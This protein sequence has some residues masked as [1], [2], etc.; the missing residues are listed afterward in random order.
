MVNPT[1]QYNPSVEYIGDR[2]PEYMRNEKSGQDSAVYS[3]YLS[4]I[5][6][7]KDTSLGEAKMEPLVR[8]FLGL[9]LEEDPEDYVRRRI[10]PYYREAQE[11]L[12]KNNVA[13]IDS[14]KA[15]DHLKAVTMVWT[16]LANE[17][18][19][20]HIKKT[21]GKFKAKIA[22]IND[23]LPDGRLIYDGDPEDRL[24][25][26]RKLIPDGYKIVKNDVLPPPPAIEEEI[27]K[28]I[29]QVDTPG[30]ILVDFEE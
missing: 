26:C 11:E 8:L 25:L 1:K 3:A 2:N 7:L 5:N 14:N 17:G 29:N 15:S 16:R 27:A 23:R 20:Y 12:K 6:S 18:I 10:Q 13:N 24:A 19:V 22:I 9:T 21:H 4:I 30:E 28:V